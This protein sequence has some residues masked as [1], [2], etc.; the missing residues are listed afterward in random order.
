MPA[1]LLLPC[2]NRHALFPAWSFQDMSEFSHSHGCM[3]TPSADK[4]LSRPRQKT[5][6]RPARRAEVLNG[7]RTEFAINGAV[8]PP[9]CKT[10]IL[11]IAGDFEK[12][13]SAVELTSIARLERRRS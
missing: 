12:T 1:G 13:A 3:A 6:H 9:L 11:E 10:F 7:V 5:A 4:P 8:S 2:S